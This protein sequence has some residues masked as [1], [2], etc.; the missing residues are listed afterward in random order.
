MIWE[1][2]TPAEAATC[3]RLAEQ[4]WIGSDHDMAPDRRLLGVHGERHVAWR[5]GLSAP[6]WSG[7]DGGRDVAN[8]DVKAIRPGRR[9][10]MRLVSSQ[11]WTDWYVAV[12]VDLE[13]HRRG[14][15]GH[16]HRSELTAAPVRDLGYGPTFCLPLAELEPGLPPHLFLRPT[17]RGILGAR[18]SGA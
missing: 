6:R 17:A 3:Q 4:G 13:R 16:T 1:Q 9:D 11:T 14:V 7:P 18:R 12:L 5:L 8:V 15:L 2:I 10:L